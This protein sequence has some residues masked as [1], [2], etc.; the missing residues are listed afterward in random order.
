MDE[1]DKRIAA[2]EAEVA[3]LRKRLLELERLLG[4]NSSNSSKPPS[5]DGLRKKPAPL[6]LRVKGKNRPGGQRGHKG[7]TLDQ[8]A[9]PT[10]TILHT[11]TR[12]S[13]LPHFLG[14]DKV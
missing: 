12:C 8:A 9:V 11:V 6:S 14:M 5:S 4:L 7:H 1:K 13:R 2:L 3:F 10:H